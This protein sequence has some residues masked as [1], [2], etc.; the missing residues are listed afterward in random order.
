MS[1][2]DGRVESF[3]ANAKKWREELA[4]LRTILLDCPVTEEFKW[5][6]PCYTF[7]QSNVAMVAGLKDSCV[8]SFFKGILL[9]D[10]KGILVAPGENSRSARLVRF[11]SVPE[12]VELEDTLKSYVR[13]AVEVEKAGLKVE[14]RKDD[15]DYPAELVDKLAEDPALKAAFESLTPG[16]RRGYTL[17]FSQPKQSKTRVSR[18]EKSA[19]RILDG[20]GM[21][22]R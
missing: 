19:P 4:A 16:R 8:L 18:I 15:L 6:G 10:P 14:F 12:I 5:R 7:E 17:H 21:H 13:E 1:E 3:F 9:K 20:K 2:V 11:T 22:D